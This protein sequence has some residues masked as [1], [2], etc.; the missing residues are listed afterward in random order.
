MQDDLQEAEAA[1]L[2]AAKRAGLTIPEEERATLVR[3]FAQRR[4]GGARVFN[5]TPT[6]VIPSFT[7]LI[8]NSVDRR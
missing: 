3:S 4:G 1:L 5:F 2:A 7:F 6:D 8:S